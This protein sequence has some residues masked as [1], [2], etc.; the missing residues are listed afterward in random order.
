[1]NL[2]SVPVVVRDRNGRAV[3]SLQK[4]DFHLFD[5]SKPQTIT[6]SSVEKSTTLVEIRGRERAA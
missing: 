3:G 4:E 2:I 5:K 1:V 6:N